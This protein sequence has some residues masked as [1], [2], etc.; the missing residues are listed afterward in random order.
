M[1][2]TFRTLAIICSLALTV[3]LTGCG[4][5]SPKAVVDDAFTALK[6]GDAEALMDCAYLGDLPEGVDNWRDI[7]DEMPE[8][9]RHQL[10]ITESV[11]PMVREM[12]KDVTWEFGDVVQDGDEAVVTV[13]TKRGDEGEQ[14][15]RV[16]VVKDKSGNW[17]IKSMGDLM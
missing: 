5:N 14:E 1:K 6:E 12:L 11:M 16:N 2:K 3:S 10:Q 8:G 7:K 4:G 9:I 15:T 17:K 13:K